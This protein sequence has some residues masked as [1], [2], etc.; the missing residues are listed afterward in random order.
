MFESKRQQFLPLRRKARFVPH[1]DYEIK[2]SAI[3]KV[4][5]RAGMDLIGLKD[6]RNKMAGYSVL[7][8]PA[9]HFGESSMPSMSSCDTEESDISPPKEGTPLISGEKRFSEEGCH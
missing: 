7:C 4:G 5:I 3:R 8:P 1:K 2:K 9:C 6:Y